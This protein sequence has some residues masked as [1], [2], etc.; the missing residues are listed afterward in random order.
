MMGL[1]PA[2]GDG[3]AVSDTAE[4]CSSR[5]AMW[6]LELDLMARLAGMT[7]RETL[8]RLEAPAVHRRQH[9]AHVRLEEDGHTL[10]RVAGSRSRL[11]CPRVVATHQRVFCH[12][13]AFP[14]TSAGVRPRVQRPV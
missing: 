3:L 4:L 12:S 2:A 7:L 1:L 9:Q 8:E 11:S 6:P 13:L 14:R 5:L 10:P